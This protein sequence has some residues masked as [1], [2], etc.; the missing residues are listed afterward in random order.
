MRTVQKTMD[1]ASVERGLGRF[2]Y[3]S[4]KLVTVWMAITFA[5]PFTTVGEDLQI[6]THR[7]CSFIRRCIEM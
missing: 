5:S 7:M 1:P 4:H 2:Q 3:L 6:V